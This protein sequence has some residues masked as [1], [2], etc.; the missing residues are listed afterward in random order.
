MAAA[1]KMAGGVAMCHRAHV[2]TCYCSLEKFMHFPCVCSLHNKLNLDQNRIINT[3]TYDIS[4]EVF[5][6]SPNYS[7][8]PKVPL[9]KN[10]PA[11]LTTGHCSLCLATDERLP[12]QLP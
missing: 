2:N 7:I 9:N 3:E 6:Q 11:M 10:L 5:S 12:C 4:S 1:A 8:R